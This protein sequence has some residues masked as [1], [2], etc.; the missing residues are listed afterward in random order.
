MMRSP[1]TPT[2][3]SPRW[4]RNLSPAASSRTNANFVGRC[5]L[6]RERLA[7]LSHSPFSFPPSLPPS[8]PASPP[9][10]APCLPSH[11]SQP[12]LS[13][14]SLS[15]VSP[16]HLPLS[17]L[18]PV[19]SFPSPQRG[20]ASSVARE[21]AVGVAR[22]STRTV[23]IVRSIVRSIVNHALNHTLHPRLAGLAVSRWKDGAAE[24]KRATGRAQARHL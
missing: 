14:S 4:N 3:S 18:S 23:P 13:L 12:H 1:A 5:A 21:R 10:L 2:S 7:R 11:I 16:P 20:T 24:G 15:L 19:S 9:C 17:S 6:A 8:F 22:L